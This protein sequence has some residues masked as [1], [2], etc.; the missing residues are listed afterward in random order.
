MGLFLALAVEVGI[1]ALDWH[2]L[3][4]IV[5][6]WR[7]LITHTYWPYVLSFK[8][9]ELFCLG[10]IFCWLEQKIGFS[11]SGNKLAAVSRQFQQNEMAIELDNN[12]T[13]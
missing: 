7:L 9:V 4:P 5:R 8:L 13:I 1:T 10:C 2:Y 11:V 12:E 3:W 6:P